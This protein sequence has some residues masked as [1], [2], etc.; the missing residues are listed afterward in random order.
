MDST[1]IDMGEISLAYDEEEPI[2]WI[3]TGDG[4][5]GLSPESARNLADSWEAASNEGELAPTSGLGRAIRTL[6]EYADHAEENK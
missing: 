5:R 6:R 1:D 3:D 4:E 2:V